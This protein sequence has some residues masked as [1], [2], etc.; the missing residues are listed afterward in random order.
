MNRERLICI[1][2]AARPMAKASA[3][4]IADAVLDALREEL[5]VCEA[6]IEMATVDREYCPTAV[7]VMRHTEARG[8]LCFAVEALAAKRKSG[9][10]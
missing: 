7:W 9:G 1:I 3:A 8:A 5:A 6:G 10:R 2:T 4:P